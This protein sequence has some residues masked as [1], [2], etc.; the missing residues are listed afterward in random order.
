MGAQDFYTAVVPFFQSS[1]LSQG[2]H[3]LVITNLDAAT[4]HFFN[5]DFIS[6]IPS[7][8][9]QAFKSCEQLTTLPLTTVA[10]AGTAGTD[11][12]TTTG[13]GSTTV[14]T[15]TVRAHTSTPLGAVV[16]GVVA[17]MLLL[18]FLASAAAW[19]LLRRRKDSRAAGPIFEDGMLSLET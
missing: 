8:G 11:A 5:L 7:S 3:T 14:V 10:S 13:A 12:A 16:G 19:W 1:T 15:M 18:M 4:S 9:A 6:Y 17:G 2:D